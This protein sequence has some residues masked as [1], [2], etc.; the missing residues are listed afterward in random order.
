LPVPD[1]A[2]SFTDLYDEKTVGVYSALRTFDHHKFLLLDVHLERTERSMAALGWSYALPRA[3]LCRAIDRICRALPWENAR[4]RFDVLPRPAAW[5]GSESRVLAAV[6]PLTPLPQRLYEEGVA[7]ALADGL[8]RERPHL[9][10]SDFPHRRAAYLKEKTAVHDLLLV[11]DNG[12]I[13]EGTRTNFFAVRDGALY[14][15]GE[16]VLEGVTRRVILRIADELGLPVRLEAIRV[17]AIDTL[18]EAAL[19]GSSRDL[20]PVV[21]IGE[22]VVG[23]GRP[24]PI[25]LRLL[26]AYRQYV[27]R[28]VKPATEFV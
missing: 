28:A 10:T 27:R 21:R 13:L 17:E 9:K 8:S 7:V 18:Q 15:A 24:G 5:P 16:G 25:T 11:D 3:R 23:N 4:V 1:D 14:T 20:L 22:Q 2:R 12:R 6:Q 26:A 19:S